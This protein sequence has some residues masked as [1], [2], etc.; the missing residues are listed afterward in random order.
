MKI[1]VASDHT[2]IYAKKIIIQFLKEKG[3][4]PEDY[5]AFSPEEK[6][7]YPDYGE[8]VAGDVSS[9]KVKSGVLL[10]GTGIGMSIVANK[11]KGVRAALVTN[12]YMAEF[13]RSHNNA[14]VIVLP[15]R[16]LSPE[17]MINLLEKWLKSTF[18]GGRHLRRIDK[19][20]NIEENNFK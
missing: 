18:E 20:T 13:A 15:A 3:H 2:G 14:N 5:G 6:V 12:E 16:I 7:D 8:K 9:G 11:F 10:C 4:E 17:Y 1:A 19:I